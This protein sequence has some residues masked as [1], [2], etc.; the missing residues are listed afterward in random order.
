[1]RFHRFVL[2]SFA[3][4]DVVV[5]FSSILHEISL[6]L[7]IKIIMQLNEKSLMERKSDQSRH[8][9][10]VIN[11]LLEFAVLTVIYVVFYSIHFFFV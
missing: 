5:V 9:Q 1:M 8:E 2:L 4:Y 3:N 11:N 6:K 7:K 10:T